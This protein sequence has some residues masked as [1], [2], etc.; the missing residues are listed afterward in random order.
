MSGSKQD[1]WEEENERKQQID[2]MSSEFLL[3]AADCHQDLLEW[4]TYCERYLR[5]PDVREV[6]K[7]FSIPPNLIA[8]N[9]LIAKATG[10]EA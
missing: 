3:H 1:W 2:L 5:H 4:L 10:D 6:T 9:G 8:L 7:H